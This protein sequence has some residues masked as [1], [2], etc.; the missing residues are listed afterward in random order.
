MVKEDLPG[1]RHASIQNFPKIILKSHWENSDL[2]G[3]IINVLLVKF[4]RMSDRQ[5]GLN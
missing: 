1:G 5:I 3:K 4:A 2:Q